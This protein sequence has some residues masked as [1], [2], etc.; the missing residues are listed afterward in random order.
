MNAIN[1]A[2]IV[3]DEHNKIECFNYKAEETFNISHNHLGEKIEGII[4]IPDDLKKSDTITEGKKESQ[5]RI[6][7]YGK[8]LSVI[9]T[10]IIEP[11]IENQ[12][13]LGNYYI[14]EDISDS[15][16]L[17]RELSNARSSANAMENVLEKAYDGIVMIDHNGI[18][19]KFNSA[20]QQFTGISEQEALGKHVT[21][22]IENTRMHKVLET[23]KPEI[24]EIQKIKGCEMVATRVPIYE[25]GE[26]VGV[27]G[28]V[29]FRDIKEVKAL[30]ERLD[31]ATN[32]L[33]YYK[34]EVRKLKGSKYN[35]ENIVGSSKKIIEAKEMAKIASQSDSTVLIRGESG[36]GKELFAHAIHDGSLRR[37]GAFIRVNCAAIPENLLEAELFGYEK[38]AFTGANKEGKPG[39]FELA[40]GG[41]IFLDEIGDMPFDMQV[42][43][44]RA[45]QEREVQRIGSE[46][47]IDLDV[48][49][50]ASTNRNLEQLIAQDK[51]RED[52]YYRLNVFNIN[53]PPLREMKDDLEKLINFIIKDL[54]D[55]MGLNVNGVSSEANKILNSYHWPGNIRELKNVLERS[56]NV[57]KGNII[58]KDCIPQYLLTWAGA[59][60]QQNNSNSKSHEINLH[61]LEL[62][63][64]VKEA[65]KLAIETALKQTNNNKK[66]AAELLNI[67][68]SGL[69]K[70]LEEYNISDQTT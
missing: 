59:E 16:K 11:T 37:Y 58:T 35:F 49:I 12:C 50:I 1:D 61:N 66:K 57:A 19:T 28:K 33:D 3:T 56:M 9:K 44:L 60:E 7:Y 6:N 65:E 14:F 5:R 26:I 32:E 64:V 10:P 43:L 48:R 29:L 23:G 21:E 31:A 18:I 55:E 17:K 40:N 54:N 70:K 30:A 8:T 51:F 20:Y 52:L 4:F 67:H 53:V 34:G 36:T 15:V 38:G 68:R 45:L 24:G 69:Y 63:S 42:K 46:R 13:H 41:T 22:V 2:L 39:K 25:E 47:V 27:L 62:R